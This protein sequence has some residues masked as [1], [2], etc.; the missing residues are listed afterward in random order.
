MCRH[1]TPVITLQQFPLTAGLS[2]ATVFWASLRIR[3]ENFTNLVIKTE[4]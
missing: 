3:P 2:L 1:I 4:S